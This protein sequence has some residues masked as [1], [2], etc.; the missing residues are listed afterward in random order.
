MTDWGPEGSEG[1]ICSLGDTS[2]IKWD[3]DS[4]VREHSSC[5]LPKR[6]TPTSLR[7]N[8]HSNGS[9]KFLAILLISKVHSLF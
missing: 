7:W 9:S 8:P 1:S 4:N 6:S 2:L 3:I 5:D